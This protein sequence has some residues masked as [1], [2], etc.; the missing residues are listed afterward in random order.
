[1]NIDNG[2]KIPDKDEVGSSNLPV[3]NSK[4]PLKP[5][6]FTGFFDAHTERPNP[7]T[8]HENHQTNTAHGVVTGVTTPSGPSL[9]RVIHFATQRV[10]EMGHDLGPWSRNSLNTA[11]FTCCKHCC[12]GV[13]ATFNPRTNVEDIATDM[14]ETVCTAKAGR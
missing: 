13:S 4:T 14:L 3:P 10:G 12:E 7:T 11:A 6:G 8:S 2:P 1:M 5:Q 9:D